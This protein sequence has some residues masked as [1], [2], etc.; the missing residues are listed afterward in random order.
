M[1]ALLDEPQ[2][3]DEPSESLRFVEVLTQVAASGEPII[4]RRA[5]E[6]FAAV[7]PLGHLELL[8]DVL[9]MREAEQIARSIDWEQAR[10]SRPPREWFE[11]DEPKPF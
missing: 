8:R 1:S 9:A 2:R 6:D 3:I 5:G 11:G 4:V 10:K 7:I